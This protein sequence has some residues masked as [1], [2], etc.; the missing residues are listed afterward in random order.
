M[1]HNKSLEKSN[2]II[3]IRLHTTLR[4]KIEYEMIRTIVTLSLVSVSEILRIHY[5]ISYDAAIFKVIVIII[6]SCNTFFI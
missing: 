5:E 3:I 4:I 2:S 1:K 6:V